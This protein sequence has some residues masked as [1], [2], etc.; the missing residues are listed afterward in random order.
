MDP[1]Q[2][3]LRVLCSRPGGLEGATGTVL[4]TLLPQGV[5]RCRDKFATECV[6]LGGLF[7][8]HFIVTWRSRGVDQRQAKTNP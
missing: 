2:S 7:W 3:P 1:V 4:R 6:S 5:F 8:C